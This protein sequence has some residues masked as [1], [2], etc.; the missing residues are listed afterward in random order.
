M[1][2]EPLQFL[3]AFRHKLLGV[4]SRRADALFELMD[5]LLLTLDPRSPVELP[6]LAGQARE[7]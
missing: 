4:F 7:Q 1:N 6:V 2:T 5:A 3:Q